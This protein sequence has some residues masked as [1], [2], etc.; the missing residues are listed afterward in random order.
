MGCN[1][2][3]FRKGIM[4]LFPVCILPSPF[5]AWSL[6]DNCL[7][8][9]QIEA[10]VLCKETIIGFATSGLSSRS[11]KGTVYASACIVLPPIVTWFWFCS[12]MFC[13]LLQACHVVLVLFWYVLV[14]QPEPS[15]ILLLLKGQPLMPHKETLESSAKKILAT[16]V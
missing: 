16:R 6:P 15:N 13:F 4:S 11:L 9:M 12:G 14:F 7:L 3:G 10:E 8:G 5:M 2:R 1:T